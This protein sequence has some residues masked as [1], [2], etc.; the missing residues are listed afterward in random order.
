MKIYLKQDQKQH[1]CQL[2]TGGARLFS[3]LQLMLLALTLLPARMAAQT[4]YDASVTFTAITGSDG[5]FRGES[6]ENLFD[7]KKTE[8]DFSKWCCNF[9]DPT[10]VIFEASLPGTPVGYTITTG[11]DNNREN[12]RNPKSW[13]LYGNNEGENGEWTLIQA[14]TDDNVL[15]D[16]N[17][18]PYNFTCDG[19][20]SYKYFKWEITA[21]KGSSVMQLA[22]FEL[23]LITCTHKKED[24]SSALGEVLSTVPATCIK[25]S[26]ST[27]KCSICNNT[28]KI[29]NDGDFAPHNIVHHEA[30]APKCTKDGNIEYW[31]CSACDKLFYDE[32]ATGEYTDPS[33][34]VISAE[35]HKLNTDDICTVCGYKHDRYS[36]IAMNG[37]TILSITDDTQ[38]P[39]EILNPDEIPEFSFPKWS[40]GLMSNKDSNYDTTS[41][42]T[43]KFKSDKPFVLSFNYGITDAYIAIFLDDGVKDSASEDELKNSILPDNNSWDNKQGTIQVPISAGEHK[44]RLSM[45]K[46]DSGS[47]YPARAFIY[48]MKA[49]FTSAVAE[50]DQ[51]AKAMTLKFQE[52]EELVDNAYL[53]EG[54]TSLKSAGLPTSEIE[55]VVVDESFKSYKPTS[56]QRLF[57]YC[58][59]LTKIEGLENINT[60]DV[61]DMSYMFTNCSSLKTLDLSS[62]NTEKVNTVAVSIIS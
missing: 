57:S 49:T 3:L 29:E 12:G 38:Y 11:N 45:Y 32:L 27:Y 19:I 1:R 43:I 48:N 50:Y 16:E 2:K 58:T 51:G 28:V 62:L 21:T 7:G 44:L 23:K 22:E 61:E 17:Y 9:S 53:V 30:K 47:D 26:Y 33:A 4:N 25:H 59:A 39:W 31:Q 56:L 18:T 10:Y 37:I 35:G 14:V 6:Y 54:G 41:S 36:Q 5:Y 24:G 55:S 15:Q 20:G 60:A 40:N 46:S 34:I 42:S 13:K 52:N 8:S